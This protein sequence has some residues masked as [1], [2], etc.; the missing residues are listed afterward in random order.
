MRRRRLPRCSPSSVVR[1]FP[2]AS[3]RDQAALHAPARPHPVL[4]AG[5]C[6]AAQGH[7]RRL[8]RDGHDAY[9]HVRPRQPPRRLRLLPHG[10]R[11]RASRRS[12]ASRRTSPRSRGATSARS[13]GASRTRSATTCPVRVVTP[14]RRSGR[15]TAP[16]CTTSSG[17][18]R[19]RT[20]RAGCTKWPRMDKE[21][22]SQWSEGLIASTGCPSG[23]LQTRLRLGQFDEAL[24]GGLRVPG[25]LRQGPVL[26]GADGPR[27]R[28][29]APGPRR[30]PGD[31]QEARHPAAGHER[32]ALHVRARGDRARRPALH[33][34]RQEPLGP[35][36]LPLRRHRLLPEDHGRDVRHRLLG[37][38]AGGLRQHPPGRRADRHHRHVREART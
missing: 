15:R 16:A 29:R 10:A 21:T 28:D 37:R 18:P 8:Q 4:A 17:S 13:S 9:R 3:R 22:I 23:E 31:R 26:P 32:L 7:V 36:P 2:E 14:T 1:R 25:H 19:T 34:D 24:Q 20:P 30:P 12:S 5:R 6:R 38:L 11:R 27:H 35:G 33:P